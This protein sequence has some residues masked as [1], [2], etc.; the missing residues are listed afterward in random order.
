MG[1]RGAFEKSGG[2]GINVEDREYSTIGYLN[3]IKVLEWEKGR[4]NATITYSNKKNTTYYSYS[5][6]R[7]RIEHIYYYR[8]HRLV[9]SVDFYDSNKKLSPHV[10]YWGQNGPVGRGRYDKNNVF[11]LNERDTRLFIPALNWKK[12]DGK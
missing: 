5:S 7:K 3:H 6:A 2:T 10:H 12:P 11:S 1:G 9:K 8:N 4:N